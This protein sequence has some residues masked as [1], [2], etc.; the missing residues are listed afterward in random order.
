MFRFVS[1]S[2]SLPDSLNVKLVEVW[3]MVCL[4]LP[5]V[6]VTLQTYLHVRKNYYFCVGKSSLK[7]AGG[8]DVGLPT[9]ALGRG[10]ISDL[11]SCKENFLF[12]CGKS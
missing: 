3:M 1:V 8:L 7:K 6:E 4:L 11:Y 10:H 12:Q 2:T 5:L 9:P